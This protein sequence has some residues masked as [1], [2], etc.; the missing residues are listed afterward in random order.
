MTSKQRAFLKRLA[1]ELTPVLQIGKGGLTPE[2]TEAVREAMENRELM[3]INILKSCTDDPKEIGQ[4]LAERTHSE[5]VQV[6]G[7]KIVLYREAKEP[8]KR[9]IL[10]PKREDRT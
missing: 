9:K 2:V 6:I 7:K 5:L 4:M 3:K 8:E 1:M 10:L